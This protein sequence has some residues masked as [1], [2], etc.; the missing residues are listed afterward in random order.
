MTLDV[1]AMDSLLRR[2]AALSDVSLEAVIDNQRTT[3][4]MTAL[5]SIHARLAVMLREAER[6]AIAR[7]ASD[8]DLPS[9]QRRL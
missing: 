9:R 8:A 5:P 7:A 2:L 6:R 3:C 4:A 1:A